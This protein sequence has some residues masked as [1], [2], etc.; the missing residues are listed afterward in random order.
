[1]WKKSVISKVTVE[2]SVSLFKRKEPRGMIKRKTVKAEVVEILSCER[3]SGIRRDYQGE[4]R[5]E[6]EMECQRCMETNHFGLWEMKKSKEYE[7]QLKRYADTQWDTFVKRD[8]WTGE[9]GLY[10]FQ[11]WREYQV[12]IRYYFKKQAMEQIVTY[13]PEHGIMEVGSELMVSFWENEPENILAIDQRND[14]LWHC[15]D[16]FLIVLVVSEWL[17]IFLYCRFGM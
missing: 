3:K 16:L 2:R 14:L 4:N 11:I 7:E 8:E 17:A 10:N 12:K 15:I 6:R 13:E 5:V 1:M 9:S